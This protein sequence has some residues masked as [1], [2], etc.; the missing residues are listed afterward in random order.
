VRRTGEGD[1]A[2]SKADDKFF[3]EHLEE[4]PDE[5]VECRDLRHSWALLQKFHPVDGKT[6][7]VNYV[8]RTLKCVRCR[9]ERTDVLDVRTFDRV[10]TAYHYAEGYTIKGNKAGNRG[11]LIRREAYRRQV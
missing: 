1:G 6:K 10:S 3:V 9:T 11:T 5:F 8:V 7:R 2:M 4:L